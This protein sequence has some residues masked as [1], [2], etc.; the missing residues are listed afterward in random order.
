MFQRNHLD[1][2]PYPIHPKDVALYEDRLETNINVYSFF[3]DE[4][5]ARHPM[6]ISRKNHPRTAHLL[7]WNEHYAP[8]HNMSRLFSDIT[9]HNGQLNM[10]LRCLGH[11]RTPEVLNRHTTT[12]HS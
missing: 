2:L 6:F 3:D 9:K 4:G 1:D 10:C 7:Y 11:F 8:I 5:K 12:L